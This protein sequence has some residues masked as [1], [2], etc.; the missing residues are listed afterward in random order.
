MKYSYEV[1]T[2]IS[3]TPHYSKFDIVLRRA[4]T[5]LLWFHSSYCTISADLRR[6]RSEQDSEFKHHY[7]V[8][9]KIAL[10]YTHFS[11]KQCRWKKKNLNSSVLKA[12]RGQTFLPFSI[13]I[14]FNF[15][16]EL[17]SMIYLY[18]R[19]YFHDF[20]YYHTQRRFNFFLR[21]SSVSEIQDQ[22]RER[23][24]SIRSEC[25]RLFIKA[26]LWGLEDFFNQEIRCI[27]NWYF[28]Y[29]LEDVYIFRDILKYL[30]RI[31]RNENMLSTHNAAVMCLWL[32]SVHENCFWKCIRSN[33][34]YLGKFTL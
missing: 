26:S 29:K 20:V 15:S 17:L 14:M 25:G 28:Y 7:S 4:L 19:M 33:W 6:S 22:R 30:R 31:V 10:W 8:N 11:S 5:L 27:T 16:L 9:A 18:L 1:E 12:E 24:F 34:F 2:C 3:Q 32:C 21:C 13:N 23:Q